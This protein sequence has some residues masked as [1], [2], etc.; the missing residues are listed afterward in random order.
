MK[1][2]WI[3]PKCA[4]QNNPRR[5]KCWHCGLERAGDNVQGETQTTSS[6]NDTRAY[7]KCPFCG[8]QILNEAIKCKYCGEFIEDRERAQP[9]EVFTTIQ[10]DKAASELAITRLNNEI[11]ALE[12]ELGRIKQRTRDIWLGSL[13]LVVAI[14]ILI[15][16]APRPGRD[17]VSTIICI[18][19]AIFL[20]LIGIIYLLRGLTG[21]PGNVESLEQSINHKLSELRKH[22]EIVSQ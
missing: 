19:Y 7:K 20:G 22:Q 12:H 17:T 5:N 2:N 9:K 11:F 18:G 3:C 1:D 8:E 15:L 4:S 13:V 10:V 14:I 21:S 6:N 16:F